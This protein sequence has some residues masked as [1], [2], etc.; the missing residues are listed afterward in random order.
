LTVAE[1]PT[2]EDSFPA[3]KI[4]SPTS[5]SKGVGYTAYKK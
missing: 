4:L 3:G 2:L 1:W 5:K